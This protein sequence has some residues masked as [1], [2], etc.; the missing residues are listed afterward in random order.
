M[1]PS[2]RIV[3]HPLLSSSGFAG[4]RIHFSGSG[5]SCGASDGGFSSNKGP[6]GGAVEVPTNAGYMEG[7]WWGY[8][9]EMLEDTYSIWIVDISWYIN[10]ISGNSWAIWLNDQNNSMQTR[11]RSSKIIWFVLDLSQI[12]TGVHPRSGTKKKQ[13]DTANMFFLIKLV[14]KRVDSWQTLKI[15]EVNGTWWHQ[16]S[17]TKRRTFFH[18]VPLL[19]RQWKLWCFHLTPGPPSVAH[20]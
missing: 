4:H 15:P 17:S 19:R 3:A 11:K 18:A 6:G 20:Q 8:K 1:I 14:S 12:P 7:K 13:L 16:P 5:A 2:S 10:D 9:W